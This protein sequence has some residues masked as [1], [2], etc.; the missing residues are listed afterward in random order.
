MA[1]GGNSSLVRNTYR[2]SKPCRVSF[3]SAVV[4]GRWSCLKQQQTAT[5]TAAVLP[6]V[7]VLVPIRNVNHHQQSCPR[8]SNLNMPRGVNKQDDV[9]P[10]GADSA[11]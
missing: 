11:V 5:S 7:R 2:R 6:K 4:V 9:G 3:Q 10:V 8:Q 1:I